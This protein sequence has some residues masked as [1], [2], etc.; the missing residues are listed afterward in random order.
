MLQLKR[1]LLAFASVAVLANMAQ[2]QTAV[3][4]SQEKAA[5]AAEYTA[6]EL[7]DGEVRKVDKENKKVTLK[8]G[9]L[10]NLDMPGMTMVFQVGDEAMLE[11]LQ[12]GDKVRFQAA[13]VDGKITAT[14][15]ETAR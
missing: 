3:G 11:K 6:T 12:V 13:K 15:I 8:H 9:P 1:I 5:T 10:K 2:A 4:N 14:K 7:T